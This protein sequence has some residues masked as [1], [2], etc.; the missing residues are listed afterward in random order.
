[1]T[2]LRAADKAH[3]G[4]ERASAISGR[5]C[6]GGNSTIFLRKIRLGDG[7]F[8]RQ[9]ASKSLI[10]RRKIALPPQPKIPI[11]PGNSAMSANNTAPSAASAGLPCGA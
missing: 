3:P 4:F 2:K 8:E 11:S 1:M 5:W 9:L 6:L 7:V 10:F